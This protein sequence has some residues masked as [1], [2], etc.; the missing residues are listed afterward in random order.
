MLRTILLLTD[1]N[2]TLKKQMFQGWTADA[3]KPSGR[4]FDRVTLGPGEAREVTMRVAPR[5][6]E[7]WSIAQNRWVASGARRV[8]VGS[9]S[10]D[11]KLSAQ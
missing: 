10:R 7:Y 8:N 5:S 1:S 2:S 4:P 11:L 3:E 9:S 6:L